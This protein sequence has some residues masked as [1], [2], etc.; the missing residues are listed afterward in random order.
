MANND[1]AIRR[2]AILLLS[3]G[4]EAAVEVFKYLG[5]KEVQKIGLA[6]ASMDNVTREQVE[7]VVAEFMASTQNRANFG[8]A[9]EYIRS[10]LT[11]ALGSDK[12]ANLLDRILQGGDNTGIEALKWM[13]SVAVA[14]LIKNEHPQIIAT[15]LVHLEPDQ[16][17]EILNQFVE[18]LR[19][20]VLLRIATL[21]GVQP[22]A[23]RELN[24]V[25]TQLLSGADRVK[26]S[27]MGGEGMAAEIL[28]F[29]GGVVEASALNAIREYDPELAQ[30]IQDKMFTFENVIDIDDRGIQ[31][32][33]REVSS[34]SL[35]IAMKG[36]SELLRNKIFKNMSQRA[37][38]MLR[39]DFEAK[40]AVKVSDVE[41]E[42]REILKVVR[43]L[44]DEGQIAIA[45]GGGEGFVE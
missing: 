27:A 17:S 6:M 2:S 10:V 13:D 20:D 40:G 42:Q 28:N 33:L 9:D 16:V 37:A 3:L 32:L 22:T 8:A 7:E 4:E 1:E 43:R 26:K 41:A 39:D 18:R 5:P 24:D 11:K 30:R 15:I 31:M 44:A 45:K 29:M 19:N 14:E 34:D 36:T 25:L 38:E 21:E 35:I 12:A 23:L